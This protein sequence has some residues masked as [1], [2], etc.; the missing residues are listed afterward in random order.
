MEVFHLILLLH[1]QWWTVQLR[2]AVD[3]EE[4]I[5]QVVDS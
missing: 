3:E 2:V 5:V 1:T 4:K